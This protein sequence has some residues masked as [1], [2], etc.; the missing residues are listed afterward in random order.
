MWCYWVF[1]P[2]AQVGKLCICSWSKHKLLC[3]WHSLPEVM[4]AQIPINLSCMWRQA[5]LALCVHSSSPHYDGLIL[6]GVGSSTLDMWAEDN[7]R[8]NKGAGL[9]PYLYKGQRTH[10]ETL[11]N[12]WE[13]IMRA[14]LN[15][16]YMYIC[17]ISGIGPAIC[18]SK[19]NISFQLILVFWF[20]L[21]SFD[22]IF[23][24]KVI[25]RKSHPEEYVG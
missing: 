9:F 6:L 3:P 14:T 23:L 17:T 7:L 18:H 15:Y 2:P 8:M 20:S 1:I 21:E 22:S 16:M 24:L 10:G 11:K 12:R 5:S 4:S 25:S 19:R 13:F